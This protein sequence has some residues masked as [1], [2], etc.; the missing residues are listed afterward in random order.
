VIERLFAAGALDV[1]YTPVM[2]KKGRPATQVT[3]ITEPP[4][5]PRLAEV[6]L[7]EST[8]LGVRIAYEERMELPRRSQTVRTEFGDVAVKVAQRPDGS[9]RFAP[10]YESVR[11]VAEAA[12]VPLADVYNAALRA[13]G[14]GREVD[15]DAATDGARKRSTKAPSQR[16]SRQRKAK[17]KSKLTPRLGAKRR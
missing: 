14:K 15:F 3:V 2:M 5:A 12:G 17:P 1:F 16:S 6:L 11:R 4:D 13:G 10:E 8:T 9:L 7:T